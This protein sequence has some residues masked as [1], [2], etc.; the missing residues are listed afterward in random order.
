VI[1][2]SEMNTK[3]RRKSYGGEN[4][5]FGGKPEFSSGAAHPTNI[6]WDDNSKAAIFPLNQIEDQMDA[7]KAAPF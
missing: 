7:K 2:P 4:I 6:A 3:R 1:A 5:G